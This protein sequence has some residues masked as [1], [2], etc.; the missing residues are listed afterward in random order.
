MESI[1]FPQPPPAEPLDEYVWL[2]QTDRAEVGREAFFSGRKREYEVFGRAARNL[3]LNR[4]GG[5]TL[6]FQGAPGAGKTAL[7]LECMEAVKLH[8]KPEEPWV[9][10]M[11]RPGDLAA[12]G[13]VALQIVDAVHKES[14]RLAHT[15]SGDVASKLK[16]L[17]NLGGKLLAGLSQRGFSFAGFAVPGKPSDSATSE[18]RNIVKLLRNFRV[19][20]YIDEAQN[21][22]VGRE[23]KNV[24]EIL[25]NPIE[26]L[27]L[28]AAFFGLSGTQ[29]L[30]R[31]CGLSRPAA[32]RVVNLEPLSLEDARDSLGRMLDTYYAGTDEEKDVWAGALAELSQGWPQHINRIGVAAGHVLCSNRGKLGRHLLAQAL[33]KGIQQKNAYYRDRIG[34][35]SH[36]AWV[37]RKLALA[38]ADKTGDFADS[39]SSEEI[40]SLTASERSKKGETVDDFLADAL[41][42]GLLAP[43]NNMLD[44]YKIPIPSL[45]DYLRSLRIESSHGTDN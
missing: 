32:D 44:R 38:A 24:I 41:H 5:E 34:A 19:V 29:D 23:T 12:A 33:E 36:R 20:I 15:A 26:G 8:S 10:A 21:I 14:M 40:E 1:A 4:V 27:P 22:P 3:R 16:Q 30:L 45:G 13:N 18:F 2:D 11:L 43:E 31:D 42:A 37:Y 28:V 39:L 7:R 25:H 35:G 9:A 6:I 17:V